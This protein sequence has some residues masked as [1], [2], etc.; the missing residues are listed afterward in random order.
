MTRQS[1]SDLLAKIDPSKTESI[2]RY[3]SGYSSLQARL[4]IA[5]HCVM[6]WT[7]KENNQFIENFFEVFFQLHKGTKHEGKKAT[8]ATEEFL[9]L[10]KLTTP[11]SDLRE[12][13]WNLT[14]S[15]NRSKKSKNKVRS[16]APEQKILLERY[17]WARS[18]MNVLI[19]GHDESPTALARMRDARKDEI[20]ILKRFIRQTSKHLQMVKNKIGVREAHF[21]KHGYFMIRKKQQE[22]LKSSLKT[23]E[24]E[25]TIATE[26][27]NALPSPQLDVR[28]EKYFDSETVRF[29]VELTEAVRQ[30]RVE[31][32]NGK[33]MNP[34]PHR[35]GDLT[36]AWIS[37][38]NLFFLFGLTTNRDSSNRFKKICQQFK[39][40]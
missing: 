38:G 21:K 3:L 33:K 27:V 2:E 11:T 32:F 14:P 39:K 24:A 31:V 36:A 35:T 12:Q 20:D 19:V 23:I 6:E 4:A 16:P 37:L 9:R 26:A 7:L 18:L 22:A 30:R 25:L 10:V 29:I 34:R 17:R 13:K 8:E 40:Q 28:T 1:T 5:D 15:L